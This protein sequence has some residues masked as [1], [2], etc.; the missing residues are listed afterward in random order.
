MYIYCN[1]V[2]LTV[3]LSKAYASESVLM[4]D[5]NAYQVLTHCK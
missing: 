1:S 2:I 4:K 5:L 3:P